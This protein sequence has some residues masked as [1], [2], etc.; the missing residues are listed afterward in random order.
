MALTSFEVLLTAL[1][2][3]VSFFLLLLLGVDVD[4]FLL[5]GSLLFTGLLVG[6]ELLLLL[7]EEDLLDLAPL[8]PEEEK[9][10]YTRAARE[11]NTATTAI[12][13]CGD[14]S[15]AATSWST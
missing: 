13:P 7:I 12:R 14:L 4:D 10:K 2:V 3:A 11:A 8:E 6:V 1:L 5:L 9:Y 15:T